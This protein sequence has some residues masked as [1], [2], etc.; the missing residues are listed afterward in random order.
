MAASKKTDNHDPRA[1]LLL[2][3]Y[4]LDKYHAE[5][6]ADVLDCCQAGGFLW[7]ELRTTHK[8]ARYWGVDLKP[9]KGRLK[10]DSE[11]ILQQ[12]GW[13]QNVID[14][15]TYGSPWKHWVAI[16]KSLPRA[17]TVFLT[18]GNQNSTAMSPNSH[19]ANV[20]G[21]NFPPSTPQSISGVI[22]RKHDVDYA[23][24]YALKSAKIIEC[25]EASSTGN[26]RYI[27][28]R[29]EPKNGSLA[30]EATSKPKHRKAVKEQCNV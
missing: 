28:V 9:K 22:A 7:T 27:G 20:L 3:R 15:D 8:V 16:L 18:I 1:K 21:M 25:V 5:G 17:V 12:S 30:V 6:N 13:P 10:I 19:G 24:A 11:R 2:R 26:A 4:F 23:L 14:I 29:L